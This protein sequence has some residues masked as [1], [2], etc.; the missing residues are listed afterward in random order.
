MMKV[1]HSIRLNLVDFIN[2]LLVFLVNRKQYILLM[3]LILFNIKEKKNGKDKIF[4]SRPIGK[5]T[6]L[7]LD[8]NRYREDLEVLSFHAGVRVLFMSQKAPGWLVKQFYTKLDDLPRYINAQKGSEDAVNHKKAYEF[9]MEFLYRF[10]KYVSVNCVTTV[11]YRYP[12]D[13]NWT[14]A[15]DRLGVPFIMLY[16][17]CLLASDNIYNYVTRRTRKFGH[18]HGSHIIVHN[19]KCK[20]MFIDSGYASDGEVS[21]AGALR[22]DRFLR[23]INQDILK[24]KYNNKNKKFI[25]FYFPY[26]M[27]LFGRSATNSAISSNRYGLYKK[28]WIARKK[29][30]I[31]LHN[32]I[33]ELSAEYPDVDFIIKPK[34]VMIENKSWNLY[35]YVLKRSKINVEKLPNYKV[36]EHLNVSDNIVSSSVICGLQSSVVLESA[37]AGKRLI[38]PLFYD[39]LSSP[40][41]NDFFWKDY[42][43]L[44][45]VATNKDQFKKIFRNSLNDVTVSNGVQYKRNK[46]FSK[47]FWSVSGES[48]SE[49]YTIIKNIA[50]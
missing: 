46:L 10:Y 22:M 39:Y 33:I 9:M 18:F 25:L 41:S 23:L 38:F 19:N 16:R 32:A 30:F 24:N 21:V 20:Q 45:D 13:Y 15:S 3:I 40:Y 14:K 5:I 49:Y 17:E 28:P 4:F 27:N 34:N 42:T 31:D 48:L 35:K 8:C 43:E 1:K 50:R 11:N 7:A 29:L 12:E 44:F 36:D 26:N 37:I 6:I 2:S 47:W